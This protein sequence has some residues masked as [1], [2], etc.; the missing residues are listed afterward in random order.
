MG[1][2]HKDQEPNEFDSPYKQ[3]GNEELG[4]DRFGNSNYYH[5]KQQPLFSAKSSLQLD[6][7]SLQKLMAILH[8]NVCALVRY[9]IFNIGTS[10]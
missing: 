10:N 8:Q 2:P 6:D 7:E 5:Q 4:Y 1:E 9:N 3:G